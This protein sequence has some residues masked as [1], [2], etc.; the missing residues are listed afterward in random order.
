MPERITGQYRENLRA[1]VARMAGAGVS[2]PRIAAR[3]E[4]T[5][6]QVRGLR[7]ESGTHPGEQR[8]L[9]SHHPAKETPNA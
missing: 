6:S 9:P 8:W 4:I 5:V 3:L 2:D 1:L 7:R